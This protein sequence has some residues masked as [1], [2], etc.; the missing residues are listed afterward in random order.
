[1]IYWHFTL[2]CWCIFP[3]NFPFRHEK[4]VNLLSVNQA[5]LFQQWHE[6]L[7]PLSLKHYFQLIFFVICVQWTMNAPA[8][9]EIFIST[10][11]NKINNMKMLRFF[12]IDEI[13]FKMQ[14]ELLLTARCFCFIQNK[15][16]LNRVECIKA[17]KTKKQLKMCSFFFVSLPEWNTLQQLNAYSNRFTPPVYINSENETKPIPSKCI[18]QLCS[19][20][21]N[22]MGQMP[23]DTCAYHMKS[24]RIC[25]GYIGNLQ[26]RN[27]FTSF[28]IQFAGECFG[29][30]YFL[31][32]KT[33]FFSTL[34]FF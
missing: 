29:F 30:H 15:I 3:P 2:V 33:S 24:V 25:I 10:K 28:W 20:V 7:V 31:L 8:T 12:A 6:K 16:P 22:W 32:A 9:F 17:T 18:Y 34:C 26:I 14:I 27:C 5:C 21:I 23:N 1:M 11:S 13:Y 4:H 19:F